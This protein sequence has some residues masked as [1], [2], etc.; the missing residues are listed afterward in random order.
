MKE[1]VD[2]GADEK[3]CLQEALH[4]AHPQGLGEPSFIMDSHN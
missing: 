1:G 4:D 3:S 2:R